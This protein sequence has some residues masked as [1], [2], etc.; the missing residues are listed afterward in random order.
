ME[1]CDQC[2]V[3]DNVQPWLAKGPKPMKVWGKD[4]MAW[5]DIVAGGSAEMKAR[6]AL[7]TEYSGHPFATVTPTVG[8]RGL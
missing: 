5:P 3:K 6:V 7:A 4:G 8:A 1:D 2:L